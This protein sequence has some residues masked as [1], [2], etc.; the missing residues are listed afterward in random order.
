MNTTHNLIR[1]IAGVL[2]SGGVAV[3]GL[4]LAAGIAQADDFNP[5]PEPPGIVGG[6]LSPGLPISDPWDPTCSRCLLGLP[7]VGPR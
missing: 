4:G 3:A 5:T 6:P 2:L 7:M 1:I